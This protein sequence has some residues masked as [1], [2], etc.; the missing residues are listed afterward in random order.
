MKHN[1]VL[2]LSLLIAYVLDQFVKYLVLRFQFIDYF[3]NH[4][5][6]FSIQ[7]PQPWQT[8]LIV[9]ALAV[10]AIYIYQYAKKENSLTLHISC[11]LVCGGALGN[12]TDRLLH[13]GRVIDYIAVPYF[14]VFNIA[15]VCITLGVGI[16][17]AYSVFPQIKN[18]EEKYG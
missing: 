4:G 11:G 16:F 8:L 10:T 15:D 14:S 18:T 3:Y 5:I 17:V 1:Q 13:Q 7:L 2:I 9:M 12:L 6:A